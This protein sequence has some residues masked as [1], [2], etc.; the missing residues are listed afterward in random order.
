M[1]NYGKN[2]AFKVT[3]LS[4]DIR[5]GLKIMNRWGEKIF[6]A[7]RYRNDWP[8]S[9]DL[10]AGIYYFVFN[11]LGCPQNYKGWIEMIR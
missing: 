3:G 7:D 9:D 11:L 2:E 6:A 10:P 1:N 4:D 5:G 8:K